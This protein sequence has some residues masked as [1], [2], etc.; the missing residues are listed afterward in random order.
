MKALVL[1]GPGEYRVESG[2]PEPRVK[3]EWARIRVRYA[4]ICGSDLPRF[5]VTGSYHLPMI[6]G[7]EFSGVVDTPAPG[8]TRFEAGQAVAILPI[9]PCGSCAGCASGEPFH[10]T[11]YQF[12]GSR[13]DGGFAEYC[14]VP[15]KNLFLLPE[16]QDLRSG[17]LI[18]PI[19]V[20]L[21]VLRRSGFQPGQSAIVYGAGTIG[22]LIALW[23]KV[24]AARR[25]VI[26]D[27]RPESLETARSLGLAE[28]IDARELGAAGGVHNHGGGRTLPERGFDA[29]FEAAG[30]SAALLSAI[31]TVRN[32]GRITVVGRDTEDTVIPLSSF[33]RLMRKELTL[34]GC[35]GYNLNGEQEFV[36][37]M[38]R[39]G[40]FPADKLISHEITLEQAPEMIR[41]M[42]AG[43][44]YFSKV[45]VRT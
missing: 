3:P 37:Q 15:E 2:W 30:S 45:M 38:F 20:A 12:L 19:A 5:A 21:H 6:L 41:R 4:G 33:E 36:R 14:L 9:I 42:I 43:G 34:Q 16:H 28:A 31:E 17:A 8:S 24:F 13:N 29:A 7:H 10:C 25:I 23:L 32:L 11:R 40:K 1:H 27:I 44:M 22:T 18:E 39:Q 26:A 35:W